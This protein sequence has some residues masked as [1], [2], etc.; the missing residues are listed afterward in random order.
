MTDQSYAE[1]LRAKGLLP[2]QVQF[3]CDFLAS[4]AAPHWELVSPVGTGKTRTAS[5]LAA[6]FAESPSATRILLLAPAALLSQW[7]HVMKSVSDRL[8]TLVVDRRTF[9]ELEA[10]VPVGSS[11]WPVPAVVAMSVDL[12][13]REDMAASVCSVV[14]DLLI[15]DESHLLAG[16]RRML[17][18]NLIDLNRATRTLLLTATPSPDAL[19]GVSRRVVRPTEVVG[20]DGQPLLPVF[21]REFR[22]V[23]YTRTEEERVFLNRLRE[24]CNRAVRNGV[25]SRLHTMTLSRIADSCTLTLEIN[26]R[27][28]YENWQHA[29]NRAAHGLGVEI[30]DTLEDDETSLLPADE[31]ECE[32][33]AQ[34]PP[35]P[36]SD[37]L[38]SFNEL[39]QLLDALDGVSSDAKLDCLVHHLSENQSA[40]PSFACI[41]TS[42][43]QTALYLCSCLEQRDVSV[44]CL[45]AG[46]AAEERYDVLQAFRKNGGV[47]IVTDVAS[48]FA[49]EFA[50]ECINYDIPWDPMGLEQ[51]WGRF[52]RY[53]R[54][55][56]FTMIILKDDSRTLGTW[57]HFHDVLLEK[58]SLIKAALGDLPV[59]SL[60][61]QPD[62]EMGENDGATFGKA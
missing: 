25:L 55:K 54:T 29:R 46:A 5:E 36:P 16:Q 39:E 20:W 12:A 3:A 44:S 23:T 11:P 27:R 61:C 47:L 8:N 41:W 35:V 40:V 57:D 51:R 26:L 52:I 48:G 45:T 9:M 10:S 37:F 43:S 22:Y 7:E 53:G 21:E 62:Q 13:K 2:F 32:P 33:S 6:C 24:F 60:Y 18:Q 17:V 4:G 28:L 59:E 15:V 56:P 1:S 34:H 31:L 38:A 50:D 19:P 49:M 42:F 14:W 30:G 58:F